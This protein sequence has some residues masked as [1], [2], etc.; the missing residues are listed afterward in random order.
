MKCSKANRHARK[1]QKTDRAPAA[2]TP[3]DAASR[4]ASHPPSNPL[5]L[6]PKLNP[7]R[8]DW[9]LPLFIP[10]LFSSSFSS[11]LQL[12]ILPARVFG[13]DCRLRPAR[14][15]RSSCDEICH[16]DSDVF[17]LF[18]LGS[19]RAGVGRM[20]EAGCRL[21]FW[22]NFLALPGQS[23]FKQV[24]PQEPEALVCESGFGKLPVIWRTQS[25]QPAK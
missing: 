22:K 21:F 17:C 13:L 19:S 3:L 2:I 6:P 18:D 11:S 24:S 25:L 20:A 16:F 1:T 9:V 10:F 14:R 8:N 4:C 15:R 23:L 7:V 12:T 5:V